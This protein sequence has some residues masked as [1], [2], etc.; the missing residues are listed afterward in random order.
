VSRYNVIVGNVGTVLST[1]VYG[2]AIDCFN[3]YV[4]LSETGFGRAGFEPVT[5]MHG[6]DVLKE[7]HGYVGAGGAS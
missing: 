2:E 7:H 5:L 1:D 4:E 3:D 6:G